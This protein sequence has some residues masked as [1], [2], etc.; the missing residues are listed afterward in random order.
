MY[1]TLILTHASIA[2]MVIVQPVYAK[3]HGV[4]MFF[5]DDGCN[6][7]GEL[8][9]NLARH[10]CCIASSS[11]EAL[12]SSSYLSSDNSLINYYPTTFDNDKGGSCTVTLG[13]T[14]EN[15]CFSQTPAA[16]AGGYWGWASG[17]VTF[18]RS[19]KQAKGCKETD[20]KFVVSGN[21]TYHFD[22][23]NVEKSKAF[24]EVLQQGGVE[25]LRAH[26]RENY[27]VVSQHDRGVVRMRQ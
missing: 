9:T 3:A 26:A 20:F 27:D 23:T 13:S 18:K 15:T 19:M 21:V 6:T 2:V 8:C 14:P 24:D 16:I 12:W 1:A 4:A 5:H 7:Y 25:G 17:G 11:G 10:H 22:K